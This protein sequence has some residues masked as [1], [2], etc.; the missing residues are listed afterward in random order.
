MKGCFKQKYPLPEEVTA[1]II[2]SM[3]N[4]EHSALYFGMLNT[5]IIPPY[6][7]KLVS[8]LLM[9]PGLNDYVLRML[10]EESEKRD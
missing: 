6:A 7:K 3:K 10:K 8:A 4:T 2:D 5:K 1:H 9:N